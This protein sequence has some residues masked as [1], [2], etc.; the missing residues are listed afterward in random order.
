M[1][2]L[3]RQAFAHEVARRAARAQRSRQGAPAART[4]RSRARQRHAARRP[5][6]SDDP[7][8]PPPRGLVYRLAD[9]LAALRA[10]GAV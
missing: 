5:S 10:G 6:D 1:D 9:Q 2:D 3:E 7:D 4:R 8:G